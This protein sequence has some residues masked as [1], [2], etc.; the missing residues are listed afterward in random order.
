MNSE[1]QKVYHSKLPEL[2]EVFQSLANFNNLE[3]LLEFTIHSVTR[4][5]EAERTSLFLVDEAHQELYS[6]IAEGTESEIRFPVGAGIAGTVAQNKVTI[7]IPDA[8]SDSRFNPAFDQ[9]TGFRT[10][11]ILCMPMQNIEGRVIGVIQVL[12]KIEGGFKES[13]ELLLSTFSSHAAVCIESTLLFSKMEELVAQRTEELSSALKSNRMILSNIRDGLFICNRKGVIQEGYSDSCETLLGEEGLAGKTFFTLSLSP[14]NEVEADAFIQLESWLEFGFDNP[15][16]DQ[17]EELATLHLKKGSRILEFH[18]QRIQEDSE[19]LACMV[20]ASDITQKLELEAEIA[21]SQK[22]AQNATAAVSAMIQ[23]GRKGFQKALHQLEEGSLSLQNGLMAMGPETVPEMFRTAHTLKGLCLSL[24]LDYL[25]ETL[26][27]LEDD[28]AL[29]RATQT[30]DSADFE[31][32]LEQFLGQFSRMKKQ[33]E[34][35]FGSRNEEETIQIPRLKWLEILQNTPPSIREDLLHLD[36]DSIYHL[37]SRLKAETSRLATKLGKQ[38]Q[39]SEDLGALLFP[40]AIAEKLLGNLL[41][42]LRNGLD[43]GLEDPEERI[44]SGKAPQGTL[45][46]LLTQTE[47][48]IRIRLRDDGRGICPQKILAKIQSKGLSNPASSLSSQEILEYLFHPG[49]STKEEITDVS[50]RGVGL[51]SVRVSMQELGGDIRLESVPGEGST[52]ELILPTEHTI[53]KS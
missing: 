46:L 44:A 28:L 33:F 29:M 13:D 47:T 41:H 11:N 5:V 38:V 50:G 3:D 32:H 22:E 26:H 19:V 37:S 25:G 21:R 15:D 52:F 7:H 31:I 14:I 2:I 4:L 10:R 9:K 16:M 18:F 17:W 27:I 45:A 20:L 51:D 6:Q 39:Y 43:H 36:P 23:A 40:S 53:L 24:N 30:T 42:L 48:E 12:N 8:Y 1:E 35:I 49:F 34:I